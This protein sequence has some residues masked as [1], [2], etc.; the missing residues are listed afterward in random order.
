MELQTIAAKKMEE[1]EA[2]AI[3]LEVRMS[4]LCAIVGGGLAQISK[5]TRRILDPKSVRD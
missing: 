5:Q 2:E 4:L 1:L 3:E